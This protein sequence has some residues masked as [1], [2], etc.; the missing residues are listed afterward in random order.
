MTRQIG[1]HVE[2]EVTWQSIINFELPDV[3]NARVLASWA[4]EAD[5]ESCEFGH[6][7]LGS[8]RL[9]LKRFSDTQP[10][11]G[12]QY[13]ARCTYGKLIRG[14]LDRVSAAP[15]GICHLRATIGIDDGAH[16]TIIGSLPL[17]LVE[18]RP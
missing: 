2:I 13:V 8:R 15:C 16:P 4:G 14:G 3:H 11:V 6:Y 7:S 18:S 5:W 9:S 17:D 12:S 1:R 10:M